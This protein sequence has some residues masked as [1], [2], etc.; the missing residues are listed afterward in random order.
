MEGSSLLK[1]DI[2]EM[3]KMLRILLWCLMPSTGASLVGADPAISKSTAPVRLTE[4]QMDAVTAGRVSVSV[5]ALANV[6]G[7]APNTL[8]DTQTLTISN[9]LVEVGVGVGTAFACCSPSADTDVV[10]GEA[11]D[12]RALIAKEHSNRRDTELFSYESAFIVS[13]NTPR[14]FSRVKK[15]SPQVLQKLLEFKLPSL[16]SGFNSHGLSE[17]QKGMTPAGAGLSAS[18]TARASAAGNVADTITDT[19]TLAIDGGLFTLG[20]GVGTA[21]ACC[22]PLT[23]ADV[24]TSTS[25]NGPNVITSEHGNR[26]DTELFSFETAFIVSINTPQNVRHVP[27]LPAPVQRKLLRF[28]RP[29][30]SSTFSPSGQRMR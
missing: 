29:A 9:G 21:F 13:V 7:P 12:G 17:S 3:R 18:V 1:D 24:S 23:E 27:E 14:N 4:S 8:A 26:H 22:G 11:S 16:S 25:P 10:T 30:V 15:M 28:N 5:T 2:K 6:S 19:Y 20:L